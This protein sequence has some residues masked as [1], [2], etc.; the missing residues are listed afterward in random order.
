[1]RPRPGQ[2]RKLV[3]GH[4]AERIEWSEQLYAI[5]GR[6][7]DQFQGTLDEFI[8]FVHPDD[9][10]GCGERRRRTQIGPGFTHEERIMRLDG[11]IRICRASPSGP[12]RARRSIRMLASAWT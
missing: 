5:Y 7:P 12:R 9:R 10:G 11:G 2:S 3:V 8:G 6:T 1:M 4:R